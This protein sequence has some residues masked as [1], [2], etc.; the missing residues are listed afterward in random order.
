MK[1]M[2]R[3]INKV[4]TNSRARWWCSVCV[5]VLFVLLSTTLGA[6]PRTASEEPIIRVKL[7]SLYKK[8][9][10]SFSGTGQ[11]KNDRGRR[12]KTIRGKES[13]TWQLP[14]KKRSSI[15][16]KNEVLA[17]ESSNQRLVFNG[18]EYRGKILI[19]FS[20]N[21]AQAVN[22]VGIEDYLRGVV[23]SEMGSLS[24]EESLKA[25][26]VIARTYAYSNKGKHGSEG[27]DVCDSTHCQVYRGVGAER[28]SINKAVDNTR[29]IIM[30]SDGKPIQTL[31]HATCGGMTSDN[32]KVYGGAACSYLRRVICPFCKDGLNYRWSKTLTLAELKA[33]LAR[34]KIYFNQVY[35]FE[36]ESPSLMDRVSKVIFHTDKG[37]FS[38]KGTT[39]RRIFNLNSTTFTIGNRNAVRALISNAAAVEKPLVPGEKASPDQEKF[40]V[41]LADLGNQASDGPPQLIIQSARGLTRVTRPEDGWKTITCKVASKIEVKEKSASSLPLPASNN[42]DLTVK[43]RRTPDKIEIFGRG[44]GH[45]VGL[46]QSGAIE[47]GKRNWSYRQILPFYYSNVALRRLSY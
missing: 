26:T 17:F 3:I 37:E 12:I 42:R 8:I 39:I 38:V 41:M 7:G 22:H 45:Q 1:L 21:G 25:Q 18:K 30:I 40:L 35:D 6:K 47:L 43:S 10:V 13:F 29:G 4:A 9:V 23:G 34:E 44:Y 33:G 15:P 2:D 28:E 36:Y 11:V 5:L 16:Y 14:S 27:A 32:D 24:P 20:A 31:Y 19:K 46:C